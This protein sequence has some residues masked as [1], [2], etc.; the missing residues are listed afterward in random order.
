MQIYNTLGRK[1]EELLLSGSKIRIFVCGPT[2]YDHSHIGHAR[3]YIVFDL[4]A[5]YLRH[6]GYEVDYLQNITDIDDKI[7]ERAKHK[8]INPSDLTQEYKEA[9]YEDMKALG[10]TSV[11]RYTPATSHIPEIISQ[12]KRLIEKSIAYLIEDDGYYFDLTKFPDY[13]KL[14][15]RTVE[16]A[17]DAVSRIDESNKKKNRG[18]FALWKFSKPEE[19]GWDSELGYGRPG[20]HIEDTAITEKYFGPQY[21][22][23]GGAQD[24]VFPHHEAEIAQMESISG[25]K[26]MVKYWMHSGFLTINGKKMSKS[27]NNFVTI[28]DALTEYPPQALRLM[29]LSAHYRSPIDYRPENIEGSEAAVARI[30]EFLQKIKASFNSLQEKKNDKARLA[31]LSFESSFEREMDDDFNTPSAIAALFDLM[32]L[33]NPTI[34]SLELD[35][36]SADKIIS[37]LNQL[38]DL[39]GIIPPQQDE[40]PINIRVLVQEREKERKNN[41]FTRSDELRK[42]IKKLGYEIEDATFG[43]IA[44]KEKIV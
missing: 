31:I 26:P 32:R 13:G 10:I 38:D 5:K 8:E 3:T 35:K 43:P 29:F 28:R 42:E 27:L 18:D 11:T 41:N 22:I 16:G 2:V 6:K 40:I 37:L 7:I 44:K 12:V 1:K 9:Y 33:I 39:L 19:P 17:E 25:L 14:S 24:L 4:I 20:W 23:H 21:E 36:S 34:D 30:G 15:G